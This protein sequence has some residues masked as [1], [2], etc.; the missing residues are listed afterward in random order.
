MGGQI[1]CG[2]SEVD[3]V[4]V[5]ILITGATGFIGRHLVPRVLSRNHQ[6]IAVSRDENKAIEMPWFN[7]VTF[8]SYDILNNKND[9]VTILGIPDM[10][11]HLAWPGLPNYQ[12]LF[13]FEHS[14]PASYHFLKK[15]ILA[16]V[17]RVM[18]TGTCLEYGFR[19]GSLSEDLAT[20]PLTTY[21]IAKDSLRKFLQI[22]RGQNNFNLQ[23][24]RLFYMYGPGQNSQSLLAQLD[25]ALDNQEPIFN[26]SGGEQL[27]DYLHVEEVAERIALLVDHPDCSGMINCCNGKPISV[28]RLV[29]KRI[30]DRGTNISLNLGCYPYPD[31]EPMAFWGNSAKFDRVKNPKF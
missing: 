30:S 5:K 7:K 19:E 13:H 31:Y 6:I 12:S 9:P 21:G 18:V 28:R 20:E 4:E 11:I 23:W 17:S 1:F 22:L 3:G 14:L 16:G 24:V 2:N 27:R 26:M 10:V 25:T 29:E 8:I 15:M